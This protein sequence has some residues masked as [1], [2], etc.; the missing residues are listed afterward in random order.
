MEKFIP[1]LIK[2][3]RNEK[4]LFLGLSGS[5][6]HHE[7]PA[8][9]L[10][11]H[12][13]KVTYISDT[14]LLKVEE[15]LGQSANLHKFILKSNSGIPF[16]K[17]SEQIFTLLLNRSKCDLL[18]LYSPHN[19]YSAYIG[20]IWFK[21]PIVYHT[22]DFLDPNLYK[23][24]VLLEG[25]L[26][27]RADLVVVNDPNRAMFFRTFYNLKKEPLVVRTALPSDFPFETYNVEKRIKWLKQANMSFNN[28][29]FIRIGLHVG[30]YSAKRCS[31]TLLESLFHLPENYVLIF[32]GCEPGSSSYDLLYK[33]IIEY[34]LDKRVGV[35]PKLSFSDLF[36]LIAQ[37]DVGFLLY[38][39]D[40][41]GNYYQTPGRLTEYIGS[42][43]P[44]IG[45]NFPSLEVTIRRYNLGEVCNPYD[46]KSIADAF[47]KVSN[48][49]NF[50][51]TRLKETFK[52]YLAYEIDGIKLL[53]AI[54]N[55][56]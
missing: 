16:I 37:V 23:F 25:R 11:Q 12:G 53:K 30:C 27:R 15:I 21:G 43:I 8:Y 14:E 50:E 39:A 5:S 51:R 31:E 40:D 49:T 54:K 46:S 1:P 47:S 18:Y 20:Q 44:V 19:L 52:K 36:E 4:I 29:E 32:T 22:Q 13:V 35:L 33:K 56:I 24:K 34:K 6:L 2:S 48:I 28:P 9:Y 38:P 7:F 55:L 10:S 42:G 45:S 41:L 17:K 3:P 26:M